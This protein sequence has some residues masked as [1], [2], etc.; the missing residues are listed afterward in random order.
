MSD[1]PQALEIYVLPTEQG[2]P[3]RAVVGVSDGRAIMGSMAV[4]T[5]DVGMWTLNGDP[6]PE[7]LSDAITEHAKSLGVDW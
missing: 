3:P 1:E 4:W 2:M 5:A 6:L 7:E